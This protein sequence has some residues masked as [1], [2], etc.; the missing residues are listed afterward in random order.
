MFNR[1]KC[2][3]SGMWNKNSVHTLLGT[4]CLSVANTT[5]YFAIGYGKIIIGD[6]ENNAKQI[7]T[8]CG[9]T[10]ADPNVTADGIHKN[11]Y[12]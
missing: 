7:N 2:K 9:Q 11:H 5:G 10:A 1:L 3:N 12:A 8:V 4:R 6:T